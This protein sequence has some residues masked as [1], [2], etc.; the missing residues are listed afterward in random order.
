M[1]AISECSNYGKLRFVFGSAIEMKS[2]FTGTR[3]RVEH[4]FGGARRRIASEIGRAH[5]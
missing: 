1:A 4:Q 5:V 3:Q 2:V